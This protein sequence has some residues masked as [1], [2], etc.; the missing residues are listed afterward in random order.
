[1]V[2]SS[3]VQSKFFILLPRQRRSVL[4]SFSVLF[5]AVCSMTRSD[6]CLPRFYH[7]DPALL[8]ALFSTPE[9]AG[10]RTRSVAASLLSISRVLMPISCPAFNPHSDSLARRKVSSLRPGARHYG[11]VF[12]SLSIY[13]FFV[14]VFLLRVLRGKDSSF[15]VGRSDSTCYL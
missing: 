7:Q 4:P 8:L 11:L 9:S 6:V 12:H 5:P 15:P 2:R 14:A 10:P 3:R 13:R 1:L